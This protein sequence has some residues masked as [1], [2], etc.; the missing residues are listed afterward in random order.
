MVSQLLNLTFHLLHVLFLP[1]FGE[2][3]QGINPHEKV[4]DA[5]PEKIVLFHF[6][7]S[8]KDSLL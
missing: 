5:L 2:I 4:Y 3:T 1:L 6:S 8:P 7:S